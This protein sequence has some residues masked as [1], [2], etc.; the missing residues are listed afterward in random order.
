MLSCYVFNGRSAEVA[1]VIAGIHGSELSGIEVAN[2]MRIKLQKRKDRPPFTTIIIPEIFPDQARMARDFR[3]KN[4]FTK[5]NSAIGRQVPMGKTVVEPNRQFPKPGESYFGADPVTIK[6]TPGGQPILPPTLELLRLIELVKPAR[7]AAIH[8]HRKVVAKKAQQDAPGIFVDPRYT[9]SDDC[10]GI[11]QY[12]K[13]QVLKGPFN[14]VK[15]K[16][17]LAKDPAFPL[18][19]GVKK[20]VVGALDDDGKKDDLLALSIATQVASKRKELVPGNH[21]Q[22]K[23]EV[24]HYSAS[25]PPEYAGFSLGDWAPVDVGKEDDPDYRPGCP[26][27]TVEVLEQYESWAF[28]GGEQCYSEEGKPVKGKRPPEIAGTKKRWPFDK[29]RSADLQIYAEALV[30]KFLF[31]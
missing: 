28:V 5:A 17:D 1:L 18:V 25:E 4:K 6:L 30:A 12:K 20:E 24:I 19:K 3:R 10:V 9:F 22:N 29:K 14:T 31:G 15:C 23:P 16:F 11:Y 13:G 27:I 21:L 26:V 7:I 2:W 8:A